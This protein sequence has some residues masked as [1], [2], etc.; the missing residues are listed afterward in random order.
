MYKKILVPLD[1]SE[2]A[3]AIVP[4]VEAVATP[5]QAEIILLRVVPPSGVSPTTVQEEDIEARSYLDKVAAGLRQK[6][7]K[8]SSVVRYGQA[9]EE[10]LDYAGVNSIDLIAM[11]THGRGG[12][13][14]WVFGSVAE[15]VLRGTAIP[16]LL[17]R[18]PGVSAYGLPPMQEIEL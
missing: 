7:I 14:R 13:S 6:G 12:V 15:K 16:I 2:V 9:A 4:H 3:E 1:G 18:A 5:L 10:I 11:S 8:T 17:I